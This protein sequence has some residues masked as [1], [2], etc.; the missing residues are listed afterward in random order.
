[1]AQLPNSEKLVT[2]LFRIKK[3]PIKK[4]MSNMFAKNNKFDT[5]IMNNS[6]HD[7]IFFIVGN[8]K[9]DSEYS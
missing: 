8:G 7:H 9:L 3:I 1:M 5:R 4:Q 2:T 6:N